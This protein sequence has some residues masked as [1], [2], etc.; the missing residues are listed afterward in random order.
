MNI[1]KETEMKNFLYSVLLL[2]LFTTPINAQGMMGGNESSNGVEINLPHA[3]NI[4]VVLQE[5]MVKY[6]VSKIQEL[7]CDRLTN[8][9]LERIGDAYTEEIHPGEAHVAM[10]WMMGGE[11]SE[12]LRRMHINMGQRY[13]GCV[14]SS[15][16]GMMGGG[17]MGLGGSGMMGNVP[18]SRIN[19]GMWSGL[20]ILGVL[21]WASIIAFFLAGTYFFVNQTRK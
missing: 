11:G 5:L 6:Q 2:L 14:E 16:W 20:G 12:S 3:E 15:G 9:E 13:L 21:T 19:Y 18:A 4:E 7:E 8:D 17:M 10:D 1:E